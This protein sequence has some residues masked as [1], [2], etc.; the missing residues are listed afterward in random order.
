MIFWVSFVTILK[1][2]WPRY[3]GTALYFWLTW[4]QCYLRQSLLIKEAPFVCLIPISNWSLQISRR[5]LLI[6]NP[7]AHSLV[8]CRHAKIVWLIY[9]TCGSYVS[10]IILFLSHVFTFTNL[11]RKSPCMQTVSVIEEMMLLKS[12]RR[13]DN[14]SEYHC[15]NRCTMKLSST[16]ISFKLQ[17]T[18]PYCWL[19]TYFKRSVEVRHCRSKRHIK[20]IFY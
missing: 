12:C 17:A 7:S 4:T 15:E 11:Q 20:R 9:T 5:D 1:Q 2:N 18:Y 10:L 6:L 8:T 13:K 19:N 16:C 3:N 14:P